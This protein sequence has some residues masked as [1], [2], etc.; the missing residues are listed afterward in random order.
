MFGVVSWASKR[1]QSVSTSSTESEYI[2]GCQAV[3]ELVW[4]KC[5]VT[6]LTSRAL[7]VKF[8]MDNQSAIRLVKNPVFHKN[9]KHIDVQYHFIREKYQRDEFKLEYINT[10]QQLADIFTKALNKSR[11]KNIKETSLSWNI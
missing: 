8:Y 10:S 7:E 2:A 5:L 1:Q 6:D 4:L 11:Q 3:K 9:T